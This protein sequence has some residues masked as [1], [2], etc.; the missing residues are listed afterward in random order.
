MANLTSLSLD[1]TLIRKGGTESSSQAVSST[2]ING[3]STRPETANTA[4]WLCGTYTTGGKSVF[5]WQDEAGG[6]Y[7]KPKARVATVGSTISYGAIS[8]IDSSSDADKGISIGYEQTQNKVLACYG[9]NN[10]HQHTMCVGTVTGTSI[11]WGTPATFDTGSTPDDGALPPHG[12]VWVGGIG[13]DT[14]NR[15]ICAYESQAQNAT[16]RIFTISGTTPTAHAAADF[17][18]S[19]PSDICLA[20]CGLNPAPGGNA[21]IVAAWLDNTGSGNSLY[22]RPGTITG[23][24]TNTIQWGTV[25]SNLGSCYKS[26]SH[27]S[28]VSIAWDQQNSK[29]LIFFA[30]NSDKKPRW[31]GGQLTGSGASLAI[32]FSGTVTFD[33]GVNAKA[34]T[35]S[36]HTEAQKVISYYRTDDNSGQIQARVFTYDQNYGNQVAYTIGSATTWTFGPNVDHTQSFYDPQNKKIVFLKTNDKK[37]SASAE[38]AAYATTSD[39]LTATITVNLSTGNFFEIDLQDH[40]A[41]IDTFTINESISGTQAQTF[42]LKL[43]QGTAGRIFIWSSISNIKWP[44]ATGP[45]LTLTDNAIDILK[46]T[47][48]DQGTTWHGETIGQ[49]FS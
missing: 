33:N 23:G 17:G 29:I 24:G 31:L 22:M 45:S 44:S 38:A 40:T 15:L 25:S 1:G 46:F 39:L 28:A 47:T 3:A 10:N 43:T 16:A 21:M 2:V 26:S 41:D 42:Y 19:N 48:Y 11:A 7:G 36:Y 30:L 5:A 27:T 9:T 37:H 4:N 14:T 35:A 13:S 49:N 6:Y 20:Y 8:T 12:M 18:G 34:F 32:T